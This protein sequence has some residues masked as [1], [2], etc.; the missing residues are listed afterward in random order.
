MSLRHLPRIG[1]ALHLTRPTQE[2]QKLPLLLPEEIQEIARPHRLSLLSRVG[3]QPPPEIGAPPRPKPIA[4][5]RIPQKS[6]LLAHSHRPSSSICTGSAI[7][8]TLRA[9]PC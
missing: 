8:R 1:V 7:S 9:M 5:R 4:A 3:L 6:Q 2:P